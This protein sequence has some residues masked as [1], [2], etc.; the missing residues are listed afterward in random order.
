MGGR[1]PKAS[2][3]W[4][5]IS[6]AFWIHHHPYQRLHLGLHCGPVTSRGPPDPNI[7]SIFGFDTK[8]VLNWYPYKSWEANQMCFCK[9]YEVFF[10]DRSHITSF[11]LK[12]KLEKCH[13]KKKSFTFT[14]LA[15]N[16]HWVS[17]QFDCWHTAKGAGLRK[18]RVWSARPC[19][20]PQKNWWALKFQSKVFF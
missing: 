10:V 5:L 15:L 11:L 1:Y 18:I 3:N 7:A 13:K 9:F 6:T 16:I 4:W 8:N 2:S 17:Q 12:K 14:V 19:P 20:C